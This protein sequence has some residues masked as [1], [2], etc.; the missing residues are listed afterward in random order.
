MNC[1]YK[2]NIVLAIVISATYSVLAAG[3]PKADNSAS[4]TESFPSSNREGSI[5]VTEDVPFDNPVDNIFHINIE[6]AFCADD[7]VWLVYELDGVEDHTGVARSIND[8]LAVGGYLIKKHRG[9][10]VQRELV[11]PAWLKQGDN[12]VR[13][14]MPENASHAYKIRDLKFEI[15]RGE[16]AQAGK[17]EVIFNQ[18]SLHYFPDKAYVKGFVKG[19][20]YNNV[21]INIGGREARMLNGEFE[22]VI[23]FK[24]IQNT[25]AIEVEAIYPDGTTSCHSVSFEEP[26]AADY[27]FTHDQY[28]Y[29]SE[30]FFDIKKQETLSLNG[31][32]ISSEADALKSNT[33][34]SITTLRTVDIPALDAGMVNVTKNHAGFRFLPHGSVFAK[35]LQV[36]LPFDP[37]SIPEGYTAQDIRTFYFDETSHHWVPLA[38]DTLQSDASLLI[39]KT[40]HFTDMINGIIKLPEAPGV[41]SYNS[42]SMKGIKAANPTAGITLLNAPQADN[43]GNASLNYPLNIPAGR[44]GMEPQLALTYNSGGGNGWLGMGWNLSVPMISIDTRW[45][46]PRY[47][48]NN[49]TETYVLNGEM[50]SPVAHRGMPRARVRGDER[51]Y[52]RVEGAFNKIQRHGLDPATY[53]WEVTDKNGTRYFYGGSNDM[54]DESAVL[55]TNETE[56][57][58]NIAVWCLREV[59]D[60]NGNTIRYHYKKVED[61]GV[62]TGSVKGHQIYVERVTYTGKDGGEGPYVVDFIRES[63]REDKI[64][65]ANLGFK[66]VTGDRLKRIEVK[67]SGNGGTDLVRA[68]E[69][70]YKNGAFFKSLLTEIKEFDSENN[71]F[72]TH[73]LEYY[74]DVNAGG[75][76][77][78]FYEGTTFDTYNDD[79]NGGFLNKSLAFNDKASALSGTQSE[80]FGGGVAVTI[81]PNDQKYAS[82]SNTAGVNYTFSRSSSEG[83]ALLLDVNG[84]NLP[85]KVM[86]IKNGRN[87]ELKYRPQIKNET[88]EL[89]FG[90]LRLIHGAN[91]FLK[92]T[93]NGH[94]FGIE[95]N[96]GIFA[97]VNYSITKS[98]TSIY[99]T[100]ANGDGLIDIVDN[101]KVL[102]NRL[103]ANGDPKFMDE[104][105]NTPNPLVS[106]GTL[107]GGL[108]TVNQDEI[109]L[110]KDRNPLHD[111][112][113][114][115]RAPFEGTVSVTAPVRL[116]QNMSEERQN[117]TTADGVRVSI[118][119]RDEIKWTNDIHQDDYQEKTPSDLTHLSVEKGDRIYFR[120]HSIEDG[121][122]DQVSWNPIIEYTTHNDT[123]RD[124]DDQHIYRFVAREDYLVA[125]SQTVGMPI[126]G[127]IRIESIF[128]KPVTSDSVFV[129]IIQVANGLPLTLFSKAFGDQDEAN[130]AV[131]VEA[132]VNDGDQFFFRVSA[133][134]NIRWNDLQWKPVLYYTQS[135]D[136]AYSEIFDEAGNP[137]IRIQCVPE[138][139]VYPEIL[140]KTI[141]WGATADDSISIKPLVNFY[142]F[143]PMNDK[144]LI[145]TIKKK[146]SLIAKYILNV[147]DTVV[148]DKLTKKPIDSKKIKVHAGDKL[149]LEFYTKEL[150]IAKNLKRHHALIK[151]GDSDSVAVDAALYTLF[152]PSKRVFGPMYR[153]WGVFSYNGN[154][155]RGAL[156]IDET[157]LNVDKFNEKPASID[158]DNASSEEDMNSSFESSGGHRSDKEIFAMMYAEGSKQRWMGN[159]DLTF[160]NLDT[161]SSSRMGLDQISA[162]FPELSQDAGRAFAIDKITKSNQ[163]SLAAS[164]AGIGGNGSKGNSRVVTDYMDMNGD[165]YP[166]ILG[167]FKIQYTLPRGGLEDVARSHGWEFGHRTKLL[168]GGVSAGGSFAK[169]GKEASGSP[170]KSGFSAV[171]EATSLNVSALWSKD[172]SEYTWMDINADGLPDRVKVDGGTVA[173]N[174]GYS[175]APEES[176]GSFEIRKGSAENF[177]GGL[178]VNI[179]NH[180]IQAG[181]GYSRSDNTL[182]AALQDMNGDGLPDKIVSDGDVTVYFNTGAGFSSVPV[183][184]GNINEVSKGASTSWSANAAFT[185]GF[186]LIPPPMVVKL[187]INPKVNYS[188]GFNREKIQLTDVN[189][190]GYPD[191]LKSDNDGELHVAASTIAR[192]N[193]LKEVKRPLGASFT[194][195]YKQYGNT[196]EMSNTVWALDSVRVFD[197]FSSDGAD[198]TLTS[199]EYEAGFYDRHERD[200]YGFAQVITNSHDTETGGN[201]VYKRVIQHYLN[202]NYYQKG[203]LVNEL[204]TDASDKKYL[205]KENVY[206]L[207]SITNGSEL[208]ESAKTDNAGSAFPALI[209]TTQRFYEGQPDAGKS[210][211]IK[212]AYDAIGNVINYIDN[213]DEGSEDDISAVITYHVLEDIYMLGTPKSIVVNGSGAT[214]RKRESTVNES[215]GDITQIRQ[216]LNDTEFAPYDMEYDVYG[217]LA[218]FTR[219]ENSKGQRLSFEYEYDG[220][221]HTY[222]SKVS[223]SYGYSSESTYNVKYGH[224]LTSK[225]LNGN[226]ITYELDAAGRVKSVIGPYEKG[227]ANKTMEFEYHPEAIVP[228]ALTKHHDPA[229]P[230]NKLQTSIFVDGVGRVLQTKKDVAIFAGEGKLDTEMMTVSGRVFF[231]AFGRVVEAFYP[232]TS[233]TSTA[234]EFTYE[235]DTEAAPTTTTYDVLDRPLVITL[236]DQSKTTTA[237]TFEQDKFGKMQFSTKTTDPNGKQTEQFTDVRGRLTSVKNYTSEKA[238]WTSF[239]Y[240]AIN[241]QIEATDDLGHSTLS[242]YDN[243]GRRTERKHPDAGRTTYQYDLANNLV[244]TVTAN[245]ASEG[246]AITYSYDFERLTEI[247]YP[248]NPENNVRYT[249]GEAGATD[250]RAG[251]IV[252]QEDATG[253]QEFFYGPFGEVIKNIRTVVIPQHDEQTYVTEW[254]YD[255]WNRLT[256][257]TYADGE[258]VSYTYNQGGLLRSMSGKKKNA[259][260]NYVSQLGYD[261]FE[262]RAFLAYGNG[263]KTTY[264][265]EADRRRLKNMKAETASSRVFMDNVYEYDKVNNVLG[266]KNNAPIPSSN[267]MGGASEYAYNYDDLY[268][269]TNAQGHYKGATDEH[270]Y[271][272]AMSYNT[273]GGITQKTQLHKRKDQEQKKTSYSLTYSYGAEQPHAPIHIGEQTY[274]YDANGNQTG[275]TSDVSGQRRTMMWDEENRLR[276]VYDNGSLHHY[277]YDAAG[278]RVLRGQ[279]TGQRIFVNGEWKAG[280]GQMGN[281]TVYVNPYLVLKSGGYTKHYY[282]EGQRIVSKLGGGWDNTG[283][284]PLKAGGDQVD[285]AGKG[286]KA[287]DGIVKNLKFLGADGQILT[288]GKSGKIPPGQI[289]GGGSNVTE[290]FRYFYHPDHLGNTSYVT[291]ASGEVYQHM[292]Y[293][294]FG[295]TFVEEHSNTNRTPYLFSG[296]ELDDET[297]FYYYGARYY[298]PRTSIFVSVDP[299]ADKMPNSSPYAYCF[300]NPIAFV[301][302]SGLEP[303]SRPKPNA[304]QRVKAFFGVGRIMGTRAANNQRYVNH[305]NLRGRNQK[306][307]QQFHEQRP[308]TSTP[309]SGPSID[310]PIVPEEKTPDPVPI[311]PPGE[312][313]P[314][315]D[316]KEDPIIPPLPCVPQKFDLSF[317]W[318]PNQSQPKDEA[319]AIGQLGRIADQWNGCNNYSEVSI[320]VNTPLP[321]TSQFSF[322]SKARSTNNTLM[323]NRAQWIQNRLQSMGIGAGAFVNS[324]GN[325]RL[326]I[327]WGIPKGTRPSSSV[328]I[329]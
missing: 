102:F 174:L 193:L 146:D 8:Q 115:W 64:I 133:S 252:L 114:V 77:T 254:Q 29:T 213:G 144:E 13:F 188:R 242:S 65:A 67:Y 284:G 4:N 85:D 263:T 84:D 195:S 176:W 191:Y 37:S 279:S 227:G 295:E 192:T 175:F 18:P 168:A 58:G 149:F 243:F 22:S 160:V 241:E 118:Q 130:E 237:Y 12:I 166:D 259:S 2:K 319:F 230:K 183:K 45:G 272:L 164:G 212:Y 132:T 82:K 125:N 200:F 19:P 326:F 105:A 206:K 140:V 95:S 320:T 292:E 74:D 88:G 285:Y 121:A 283:H 305:G 147:R 51:F 218:K 190:D 165:R 328:R 39:S 151:Q 99:F 318:V 233:E 210:T 42:N 169:S 16:E 224:L 134:S 138:Y 97:G 63:T 71:P 270:T 86:M 11:N 208:P 20:G 21:K 180:S 260:Y 137:L 261:K 34:F 30:K 199:F 15:E 198:F 136:P 225:D 61:I 155:G 93:S 222:T 127:K 47:D 110:L 273:V 187:C 277:V 182:K 152:A 52:P 81:G 286:Q 202:D 141:E 231:D 69:L 3:G 25:C 309:D 101:G 163:T 317:D 145:F 104:S 301:D 35:P 156:P 280:S 299:L 258:K 80:T 307:K 203:L 232:V 296:K 329:R 197:G 24:H 298:D 128:I 117:Y 159:D 76:Y 126:N 204:L 124:A 113:R 291:D 264:T 275:W 116:I 111:V 153:N 14:T 308:E 269:L 315:D 107:D 251:R 31:A 119:L 323:Y 234:G 135:D 43:T 41:E 207:L 189:G 322:N 228:W 236:P 171:G 103:D 271:T 181:I 162:L 28:F 178:G 316:P 288:A 226:E 314:P 313:T 112:V 57:T 50:L 325:R 244:E 281:Y 262:Q 73:N 268:R 7:K 170:R 215:T 9:W 161:V 310:I 294:A 205:S 297:G 40:S 32:T 250:N 92:E 201:P 167:E 293:F 265:Y 267:L 257:M 184:W 223:N 17:I 148:T 311:D 94:D 154:D 1:F 60:L 72:T 62:A 179:K 221:V 98:K 44:N 83:R 256:E 129:E 96:F 327:N 139:S 53:W 321:Q 46:V 248:K 131:G 5:G 214:Y 217:N 239:K 55:R 49:E 290:A 246:L 26:Q 78:P 235:H 196:F 266:L 172:D 6:T 253:A 219:P 90:D 23:D 33:V 123:L 108:I 157:K 79:I 143:I 249:Y 106:E 87:K 91:E 48:P 220:E 302:P 276:A 304:W 306:G 211:T 247:T 68:Y 278:E 75:G 300:N 70:A 89:Q 122:Y 38:V 186:G 312:D 36:T 142:D 120:V 229:D 245:L 303:E 209:E 59:R 238:V 274:S 158:L 289:K 255:T 173:L 216:Y 185:I 54:M 56:G 194:M 66:Q 324:A 240:N 100:D 282:I 287:F 109:N 150:A 10:K 27:I 177:A